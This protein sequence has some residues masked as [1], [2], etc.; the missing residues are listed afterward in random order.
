M[1]LNLK[2]LKVIRDDAKILSC[3]LDYIEDLLLKIKKLEEHL[4]TFCK[5]PSHGPSAIH[6]NGNS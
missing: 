4:D 6:F 2:D 5:C 3:A 1:N